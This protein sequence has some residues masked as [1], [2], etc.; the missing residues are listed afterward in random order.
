M[1]LEFLAGDLAS[2]VNRLMVDLFGTIQTS[3][4]IQYFGFW[5]YSPKQVD[6]KLLGPNLHRDTEAKHRILGTL[7]I[8]GWYSD[9]EQ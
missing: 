1:W 9:M 3:V 4:D 2:V 8:S 5:K 6:S 7:H